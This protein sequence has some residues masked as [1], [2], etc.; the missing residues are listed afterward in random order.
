[1]WEGM[2]FQT[3]GPRS[4]SPD[5]V[6]VHEE[7][8]SIADLSSAAG[9]NSVFLSYVMLLGEMNGEEAQ[10]EQWES[11]DW[12]MACLPLLRI[13]STVQGGPVRAGSANGWVPENQE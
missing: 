12:D 13:F 7:F 10:G 11:G 4:P 1:M 8:A 6:N 9:D 3:G 2:N 5:L